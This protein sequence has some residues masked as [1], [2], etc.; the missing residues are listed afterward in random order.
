[1]LIET[2][3]YAITNRD[4]IISSINVQEHKDLIEKAKSKWIRFDP[5][6]KEKTLVGIDSSWNFIPFQGFFLYA[7]DAIS[8][9]NNGSNLIDPIYNVDIDTLT[10][11]INNNF[12]NS[13][14]LALESLGI[15]YEFEQAQGCIGK[16]D[17]IIIDGSILA[18]YY[19]RKQKKESHFYE[20]V[21]KFIGQ[22][23]LL[24][25]SKTS[26]SNIILGGALG[27]MF[28]FNRISFKPGYS[29]PYKDPSGVLISYIRLS[30][31]TPCIKMEMM[32]DVS[33]KELEEII[34][35]ISTNSVEG[36]PYVLR[37]AHEKCKI[38][39]EEIEKLSNLFNLTS[40][41]GGRKVL[42]EH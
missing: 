35:L 20:V 29:E 8:I 38:S 28:Y 4:R 3:E 33:K 39:R 31:Y 22:P 36:Y 13:P 21:K 23:N 25:I 18:R 17:L 12:Y 41:F 32:Q 11:Q 2:F 5:I 37:L 10:V 7:I 26:F 15:K 42:G 30:E 34:N 1:M 9:L 16:S 40:E 19:D 27:D 14:S 6:I 24:F